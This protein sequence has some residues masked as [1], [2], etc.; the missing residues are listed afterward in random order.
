MVKPSLPVWVLLGLSG[1]VAAKPPR[2]LP[3]DQQLGPPEQLN[4]LTKSKSPHT[5]LLWTDR[6]DESCC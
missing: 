5:A 4:V 6:V 3:D 2:V 1:L